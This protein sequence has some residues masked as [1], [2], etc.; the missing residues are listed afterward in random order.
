M[1]V[2][3]PRASRNAHAKSKINRCLLKPMAGRFLKNKSMLNKSTI[4][5]IQSL[6]QK[7]FR[8][9]H[10]CF[11]AEGPKLVLELIDGR[12]FECEAVFA[13]PAWIQSNHDRFRELPATSLHEIQK[14]ELDRIAA[15]ASPNEVVAVFRKKTETP[16]VPC[17]GLCLLLDD[18]RDPGNLGTIIR[19]ADWFGVN[20]IIC[21]EQTVDMY[22]P[23]V[24][25]STMASLGRINLYYTDLLHW[26]GQNPGCQVLAATLDGTAPEDIP[27]SDPTALIIGNESAGVRE[28]LINA[29]HGKV[30]I[31]RLGMAESLNAATAAAVLLYAF[32][33]GR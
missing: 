15:Y 16:P 32:T 14:H 18:I 26:I 4:K 31:P 12:S 33:V 28:A 3:D 30:T 19:S 6:Q 13:L 10:G 20:Q 22:N 29:S 1:M 2:H 7:K 9:E 23:K 21:S 8:D 25:Q 24:V 5:Y 27:K 17:Q 11:V